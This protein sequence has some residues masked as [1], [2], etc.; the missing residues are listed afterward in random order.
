MKVA[1]RHYRDAFSVILGLFI[2]SRGSRPSW[3]WSSLLHGRDLLLQ[4]VRWQVGNGQN[5]SFWTQKWVPFTDGFYIHSSRG[6]F[7]NNKSVSEFIEDQEWNVR[8]LREHISA[9]EVDMVMKIPISKTGSPDKLIWHLDSKG[10]YIVKSGYHQAIAW[11]QK[12]NTAGI[13]VRDSTGSLCYVHGDL[14]CAESALYAEIIAIH[15]ACLFASNH[16][17]SNAIVESDSHMAISFS[18]SEAHPPWR[19]ATLIDDI[20]L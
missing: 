3:L 7:Y 4:G 2:H 8:M 13:V 20:R 9:K 5:I 19:F 12:L 16:G 1:F 14:S 10:Q 15:S 18:S 6:P 11:R 17:W